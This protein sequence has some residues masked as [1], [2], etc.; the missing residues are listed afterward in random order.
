MR[1]VKSCALVFLGLVLYLILNQYFF[2][3]R[4]SFPEPQKFSGNTFFNPYQNADS[5]KWKQ[6]N[7]H[8]HIHA[9]GGLTNGHGTA[10]N[11][12]QVYHSLGYDVAA[13]SD[14]HKVDR[15]GEDKPNY[16]P[17][18]EHGYNI[19]KN[20]YGVLGTQRVDFGDYLLPQTLSNKQ[21]MINCLKKNDE[22][23]VIINHPVL[24][25]GVSPNDFR[26][27]HGYDAIEVLRSGTHSFPQWDSA[28]SSGHRAFIIGNDDSHN[29]SR[30]DEVGRNCT[31]VNATTSNQHDI[32]NALR[33]ANTYGMK[34]AERPNETMSEKASRFSGGFPKLDALQIEDDTLKLRLSRTA[35]N[36]MFI[37]QSGS[38][39]SQVERAA[40]AQYVLKPDDTYIR[41]QVDFEDGTSIFLNPV[42]RYDA[43]LTPQVSQVKKLETAL[44]RVM[45]ALIMIAYFA[46]SWKYIKRKTSTPA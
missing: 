28:L 6:G 29:A 14:Y 21:H 43:S 41:A 25:N 46:A 19:R 36:I 2:C 38:L 4:Y 11:L 8:A 17:A 45:G 40:S 13:I 23:F 22:A 37:G 1:V 39:K 18:Y 33:T 32:L 10:E 9:W 34:I 3:P 44:F 42:F 35:S 5:S 26:F 15:S 31:W 20:H 24:R 16:L 30:P 27:L 12:R 7:F